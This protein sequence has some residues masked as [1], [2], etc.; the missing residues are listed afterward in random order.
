[1]G[2]ADK[3]KKLDQHSAESNLSLPEKSTIAAPV[4]NPGNSGLDFLKSNKQKKNAGAPK[5][6]RN[7]SFT[8]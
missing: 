4:K 2:I 6:M 7:V 1:M 3:M 5:L 8:G